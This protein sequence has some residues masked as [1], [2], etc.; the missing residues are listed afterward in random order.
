M[1]WIGVLWGIPFVLAGQYLIWGRFVYQRW[2]KE[3]RYYAL[4][5]RRALIVQYGFRGRACTSAYFDGLAM[6]DKRVRS[7]GI[8]DIAFGGPVRVD[9]QWGRAHRL[10]LRRLTTWTTLTRFTR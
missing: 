4:T 6:L 3:R 10:G 8:G 7:D 2:L 5:N 1:Q 9:L